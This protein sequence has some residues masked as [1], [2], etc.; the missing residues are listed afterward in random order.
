MAF[1][2]KPDT[3]NDPQSMAQ[4]VGLLQAALAMNRTRKA[5]NVA[6][7]RGTMQPLHYGRLANN[8]GLLDMLA[9]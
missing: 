9:E 8:V 4:T 1:G 5:L 6:R 7:E 2:D 3:M